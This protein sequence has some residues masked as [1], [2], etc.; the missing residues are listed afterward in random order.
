MTDNDNKV[1]ALESMVAVLSSSVRALKTRGMDTSGE[2]GPPETAIFP[3]GGGG[4]GID[5]TTECFG[6]EAGYPGYVNIYN[7]AI[8]HGGF[9][10]MTAGKTEVA[11][12]GGTSSLPH[13]VCCKYAR[14]TSL[15]VV[16]PALSP[17]PSNSVEY[18]WFP[19]VAVYIDP[20]TG[21]TAIKYRL[22]RSMPIFYGE[23]S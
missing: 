3:A 2:D 1:K 8:Q 12:L 14:M 7:P 10:S 19:V 22:L 20:A 17:I 9:R 11:V 23:F 21:L 16:T 18:F 15:T 5:E 13:W 6:V 4:E